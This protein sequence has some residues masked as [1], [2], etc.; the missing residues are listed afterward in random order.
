MPQAITPT[1]RLKIP[2]IKTNSRNH[3]GTSYIRYDATGGDY[4]LNGVSYS[5]AMWIKINTPAD[6]MV[7]SKPVAEGSHT[8]PYFLWGLGFLQFSSSQTFGF[9]DKPN[10]THRRSTL[11]YT[12]GVW[13]SVVAI[14][15][16]TAATVRFV[17]NGKFDSSQSTGGCN[18]A[19]ATNV[20]IAANGA[21]GEVSDARI[22]HVTLWKGV[23]LTDAEALMYHQGRL[24]PRGLVHYD[25]NNPTAVDVDRVQGTLGR[26]N[27]AYLAGDSPP[28]ATYY[29]AGKKRVRANA[30][31]PPV[32][33]YGN[34][35][36]LL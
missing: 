4:D 6:S 24:S 26:V 30:I 2:P 23:A 9:W 31:T 32:A 20:R 17:I 11:T 22:G 7:F 27:G 28:V 10:I 29:L 33:S 14:Y 15:N 16:A 3:A 35:F 5:M 18:S 13:Y 36:P 1:N 25:P 19:A 21:N 12:T 34:F 8:S